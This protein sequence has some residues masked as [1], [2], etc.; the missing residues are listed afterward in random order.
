[1]CGPN[2]SSIML[3]KIVSGGQTGADQAGWRAAAAF[4][5][6]TAGWMSRGFRTEDGPRPEFAE[7]YGA[8]ELPTDDDL[9]R[10]ERNVQDSDATLWLGDTTTA[11]AQ[12]TVGAC[13]RL[14]RPCLPVYPSATFQPA[15]VATWITENRIGT[16][17]VAGNREADEPGI[18]ERV[19]RFLEEVLQQLGLQRARSRSDT[20]VFGSAKSGV[21]CLGSNP[22]EV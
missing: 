12:A 21:R 3:D 19:E 16:L 17:N 15:H 4:G 22:N 1:M 14:G 9:A 20:S 13:H 5:V 18:G 11:D 7:R 2:E 6:S 8:T 10:I